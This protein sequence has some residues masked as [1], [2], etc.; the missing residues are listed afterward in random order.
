M[1][2]PSRPRRARGAG[3]GRTAAGLGTAVA[4]IAVAAGF[5]LPATATSSAASNPAQ[6]GRAPA[7]RASISNRTLHVAGTAG[8]DVI[9]LR[10]N[11]STPDELGIDVGDDGIADINVP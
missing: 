4:A 3:R 11:P 1:T 7:V 6:A 5:T 8:P 2:S 9:A 10:V